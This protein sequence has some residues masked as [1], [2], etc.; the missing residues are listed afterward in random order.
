MSQKTLGEARVRTDFNVNNSDVVA[1][2]KIKGAE[3]INL[4]D[5]LPAPDEFP[6]EKI[7]EYV[8]LKALALTEIESGTSW[9]V[10]AATTK[11]DTF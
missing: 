1:E 3:L 5:G 7:G 10:K 9:A 6:K 11:K 8:R 4:I 2:I